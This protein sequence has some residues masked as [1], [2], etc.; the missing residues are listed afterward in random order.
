MGFVRLGADPQR[1][2]P[3]RS[4]PQYSIVGDA[5]IAAPPPLFGT[6]GG[7]I[8]LEASRYMDRDVTTDPF[9]AQAIREDEELIEILMSVMEII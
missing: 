8:E 7:G 1:S 2:D 5:V 3:L 6:G 4:W 9:L